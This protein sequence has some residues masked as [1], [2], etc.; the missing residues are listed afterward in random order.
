MKIKL[1]LLALIPTILFSTGCNKKMKSVNVIILSGQSNAVGCKASVNLI[2]SMGQEAYDR[3]SKGF[4]DIKIAYN[5][6]TVS[7]YFVNP[8]PM[9][10]QNSSK[11][12]KFE[13]VQLG[14][15]NTKDNFG[16]EIG[17]ADELHDKWG[18]KLYIIKVASGGSNLNDDWAQD[19]D[20]MFKTLV[21]FVDKRM[22]ELEEEGLKPYL[23]AFCWMQGE[24]DSYPG[25]ADV[26]D[27]NLE[28]LKRNL[29]RAFLKYTENNNLP[30]IDAGIGP[31]YHPDT[32]K[33][34][35]ELYEKVNQCKKDFALQSP[36]NIYFDTIEAG[37]HSNQ[38]PND[39]VHYD[40]E[41]QVKLG[42][43][44]AQNLEQ[45]LK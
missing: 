43:L 19:T 22:S 11:K 31:G 21:S 9:E 29:D 7:D 25:Y 37:L 15:G 41:S 45:F 30:F 27:L 16:P 40:S 10:L 24:G 34:E 39:D 36:T 44:F 5:N 1:D 17:I 20:E 3:F 26:Y 23:R 12:G 38:E 18:K 33:N 35:W 2:N 13:K 14:Q 28:S 8:H 32:G 42:H 4:E 6:W